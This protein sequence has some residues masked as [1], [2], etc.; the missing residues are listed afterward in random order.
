MTDYHNKYISEVCHDTYTC[1][2]VILQPL[3]TAVKHDLA[4]ALLISYR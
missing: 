4:H 2:N 1:Q 3:L